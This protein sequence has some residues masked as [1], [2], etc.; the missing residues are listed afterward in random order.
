MIYPLNDMME[1]LLASAV[2]EETGELLFTDEEMEERMNA[3]K[4]EFEDRVDSIVSE[5]KNLDAEAEAIKAEKISLGERQKRVENQRDRLKRF[6]AY[7]LHGE[8]WHNGRHK[9]YFKSSET[10]E[11]DAEFVSWAEKEAPGLI[12]TKVEAD[13]D[14]IKRAIKSGTEFL[15]AHLEPHSSVVI[16]KIRKG[17][18]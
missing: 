7:L 2:D 12:R 1:K 14:A 9:V 5:I 17:T 13:R 18:E 16:Q 4:I 11:V 15:H 3:L 8:G 6:L 10:V